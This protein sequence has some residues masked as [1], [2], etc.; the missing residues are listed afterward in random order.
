VTELEQEKFDVGSWKA[1]HGR[2]AQR[3]VLSDDRVPDLPGW[4]VRDQPKNK[5][6]KSMLWG[7]SV[8]GSGEK[9]RGGMWGGVGVCVW[10]RGTECMRDDEPVQLRACISLLLFRA[11]CPVSPVLFFKSPQKRITKLL[12]L[13][14][15]TQKKKKAPNWFQKC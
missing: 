3:R 6:K 13:F 7:S 14:L 12:L 4:V 11:S 10:R 8:R 5:K 15:C 1:I 9:A 2:E